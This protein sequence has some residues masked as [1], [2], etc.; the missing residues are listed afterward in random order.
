MDTSE[1][2]M[3]VV[4]AL[5]DAD[6]RDAGVN[7][8]DDIAAAEQRGY[9]RGLSAARSHFGVALEQFAEL[10]ARLAR[11]EAS[12]SATL[13]QRDRAEEYADRLASEINGDENGEHT[14]LNCPW[15]NALEASSA[16]AG[17]ET[18]CTKIRTLEARLA[19]AEKFVETLQTR[20]HELRED[21]Y[22]HPQ[23]YLDEIADELGGVFT[24]PP[25][26]QGA[27]QREPQAALDAIARALHPHWPEGHRGTYTLDELVA[28]VEGQA[29]RIAELE[30]EVKAGDAAFKEEH[31]TV[32]RMI[33][34]TEKLEVQL[35]ERNAYIARFE[36][37]MWM[38]CTER[39]T[40]ILCDD[41]PNVTTGPD[42]VR[43]FCELVEEVGK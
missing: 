17:D 42:A 6:K 19:K 13:E 25:E 32:E 22:A 36:A 23:G 39:I 35:A 2:A 4:D 16:V 24:T 9:E 10:E 14:N 5:E 27:R 21:G 7:G 33:V 20:A 31:D 12:H 30:T 43:A 40:L 18:L 1:I 29:A 26:P 37:A 3:R 41:N 8:N 28:K 11:E 38:A 15:E 34:H